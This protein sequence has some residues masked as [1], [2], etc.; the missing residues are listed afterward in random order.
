MKGQRKSFM[1][2]AAFRVDDGVRNMMRS[3]Y[4]YDDAWSTTVSGMYTSVASLLGIALYTL[5]CQI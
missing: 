5:A 3:G 1:L 4:R 2:G